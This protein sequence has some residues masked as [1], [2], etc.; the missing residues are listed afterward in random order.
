MLDDTKSLE[1][2]VETEEYQKKLNSA[3]SESVAEVVESATATRHKVYARPSGFWNNTGVFKPAGMPMVISYRSGLW[4]SNPHWG[5]TDGAGDGRF[6][7]NGNYLRSG[8]PEGC[9]IGKIGGDH[10]GG[11]SK[12]FALGNHGF[13]PPHLEGLLW[14]TVNDEKPGFGDN[15]DFIWVSIS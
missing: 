14:L 3:L 12:T 1:E 5:P 15:T 9:L 7:A 2:L 10:E 8:A 13:V 6:T 11:G 4:R